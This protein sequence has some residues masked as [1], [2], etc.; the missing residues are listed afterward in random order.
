MN[1]GL[2]MAL[3]NIARHSP[4]NDGGVNHARQQPDNHLTSR[5]TVPQWFP[6][7]YAVMWRPC[8]TS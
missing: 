1:V 3:Y 8:F 4:I 5:A 7:H 6:I 2:H